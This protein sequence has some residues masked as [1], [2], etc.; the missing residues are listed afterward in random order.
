MRRRILIAIGSSLLVFGGVG[1]AASLAWLTTDKING[2]LSTML[3]PR[4]ETWIYVLPTLMLVVAIAG[5]S[6]LASALSTS[7]PDVKLHPHTRS[8]A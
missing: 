1:V 8:H 6:L 2:S 3:D 4:M 5:A 7:P